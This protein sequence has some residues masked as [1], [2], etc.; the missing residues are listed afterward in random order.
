[1]G[2]IHIV[3]DTGRVPNFEGLQPGNKPAVGKAIWAGWID[4]HDAWLPH[5]V[6]FVRGEDG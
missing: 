2:N 4:D 5:G 3:G 6:P 1:L